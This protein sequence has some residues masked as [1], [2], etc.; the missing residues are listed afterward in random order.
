MEYLWI[1]PAI[2]YWLWPLIIT[3]LILFSRQFRIK[4]I[5]KFVSF[6]L[7]MNY[8]LY[9]LIWII[10]SIAISLFAGM[11]SNPFDHPTFSLIAYALLVLST[12]VISLYITIMMAEK[13]SLI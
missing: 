13:Y 8:I 11:P 4:D 9:L 1:I 6:N 2:L 10:G 7:L 5:V 12:I 3:F